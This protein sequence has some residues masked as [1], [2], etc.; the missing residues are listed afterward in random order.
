MRVPLTQIQRLGAPLRRA[1]LL[2]RA[3]RVSEGTFVGPGVSFNGAFNRF[4]VPVVGL[5]LRARISVQPRKKALS[6]KATTWQC[7]E[8]D[9]S[10]GRLSSPMA[11][12]NSLG[13][14]VAQSMACVRA[15]ARINGPPAKVVR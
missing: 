15:I 4:V 8:L 2:P 6:V 1:A 10:F 12:V 9:I 3:F 7:A 11:K 13:Q 14:R 5:S